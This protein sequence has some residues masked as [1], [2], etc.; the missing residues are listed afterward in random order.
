M[1]ND[2]QIDAQPSDT[3]GAKEL[4]LSWDLYQA[5]FRL[6]QADKDNGRV[7]AI[8]AT[9]VEKLHAWISYAVGEVND[10]GWREKP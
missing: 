2:E 9:E 3:P 1:D 4:Q 7:W 5:L 10:P 8:A 6:K